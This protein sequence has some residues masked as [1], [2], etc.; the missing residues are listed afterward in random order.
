MSTQTQTQ[1]LEA[2]DVDHSPTRVSS[3]AAVAAALIAALTSAPFAVLAVPLGFGG[4][5]ILAS[6]LFGEP[7][8]ARVTL[9]AAGL[10]LSVLVAG[11]FGTP[12]EVL[13]IS[14]IGTLLAWDLGQHAIGLGEQVGSHSKT[15]RNEIVHA[16]LSAM[17][18][19]ISAAIGYLVFATAGGGRPVS[20][21]ILLLVAVVFFAWAL[22][23]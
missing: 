13:L 17:V 11:G 9:G 7:S 2:V 20:A 16:S 5:A 22:R 15:Q 18:A 14:M 23:T 4:L 8:R 19:A 21:L 12:A 6:G 10:F 3:L 1:N